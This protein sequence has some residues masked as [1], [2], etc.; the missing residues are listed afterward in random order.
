MNAVKLE[1]RFCKKGLLKYISH[2]DVLR[3]FHRAVKRAGLPVVLS[4]GF[5]PHY[6]IS[7]DKALK[8]GVESD[9]EKAVFTLERWLE[10]KEF[11][12]RINEKL[13]EGIKVLECR[14]RF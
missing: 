11:T 2:L 12:V 8:L 4:Q 13:P 14:K 10:P 6:R 5:T 1:V 9:N 7:F 3:L